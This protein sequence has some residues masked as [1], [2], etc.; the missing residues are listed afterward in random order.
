MAL[1]NP[2]N[3]DAVLKIAGATFAG[4]DLVAPA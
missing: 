2:S 1:A 4:V 3:P